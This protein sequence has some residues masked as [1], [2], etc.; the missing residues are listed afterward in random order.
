[1]PAASIIGLLLNLAGTVLAGTALVDDWREHSGGR[2]LLPWLASA[3]TW[4]VLRILR[5][6]PKTIELGAHLNATVGIT[7][8]G[9]TIRTIPS[10][11]ASTDLQVEYLRR[12]VE[13]LHAR[14]GSEVGELRKSVADVK[15][16]LDE[17]QREAA[18]A[19]KS[20]EEL[21][22]KI[23]TGTVRKQMLGLLLIGVGSVVSVL[24]AVFGWH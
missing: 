20:V 21:A 18:A 14:I 10:A 15:G 7:A 12:E 8:M 9:G 16:S 1:M 6:K 3:R 23:A 13:A 22:R 19:T 24:P 2:P 17:A 11:D 4:V 5:P